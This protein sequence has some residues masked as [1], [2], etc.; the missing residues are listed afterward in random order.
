MVQTLQIPGRE[1]RERKT[2]HVPRE[3]EECARTWLRRAGTWQGQEEC[4]RSAT[5][6]LRLD[7]GILSLL[8]REGKVFVKKNLLFVPGRNI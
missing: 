4:P 6:I 7:H 3:R 2:A 8:Q 1:K 5:E